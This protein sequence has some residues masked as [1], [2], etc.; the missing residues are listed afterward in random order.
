M[1]TEVLSTD[2]QEPKRRSKRWQPD[3]AALTFGP[4]KITPDRTSLSQT[5][6]KL[7]SRA[8]SAAVAALSTMVRPSASSIL[9]RPFSISSFIPLGCVT[10]MFLPSIST[11]SPVTAFT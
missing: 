6:Q 4:E 7:F 1:S 11:L 8:T 10:L 3:F 9:K 5:I 2:D